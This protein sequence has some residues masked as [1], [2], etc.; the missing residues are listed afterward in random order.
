MSTRRGIV[1]VTFLLSTL[2][3]CA[4][5]N[6]NPQPRALTPIPTLGPVVAPTL[7]TA[8]R[9][10][11]QAGAL[12]GPVQAGQTD[13]ALGASVYF[14]NCTA[15][16]GIEGQG[17]DAKPLRNSQYIQTKGDQDVFTTIAGGRSGTEMPSWLQSNGG[18]LTSAQIT[19]VVA[20]LHTL[21][22]VSA[23]PT[24]TP[25]PP[26]PTETPLP[27]GAPTEEPAQ[28][29]IPG[30][31]GAAVRLVGD[32]TSGRTMFGLI[33]SACHGPEGAQGVP[34]PGSDDGSVPALNPI[35]P[36]I[37]DPDPAVFTLN[38][39]L[40]VEHGSVPSGSNPLI[41]MPPFGDFKMLTGQMIADVIS[42]L[43]YLNG[44][45]AK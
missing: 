16:H 5:G 13:A 2:L 25:V 36:T 28:P 27:V 14:L 38:V 24:S 7:I 15:C 21:Q 30:G 1:P 22:G 40:F 42:Y 44:G 19:W 31:P 18:P 6:P 33:C 37:A 4:C 35:D 12:S 9:G 17:V 32:L 26:E 3:V 45:V 20:Y 29:S 43:V 34:N 23:M 10:P 8:L 41:M 39:D 11:G